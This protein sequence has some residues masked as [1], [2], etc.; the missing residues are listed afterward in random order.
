MMAAEQADCVSQNVIP[1]FRLT[2]E[3]LTDEAAA[4]LNRP[5]FLD[6][7]IGE[8]HRLGGAPDFMQAS[9]W[10]SC[11]SCGDAMT[12]YAQLDALPSGGFDLADAGLIH[13]FVC[14]DCFEVAASLD[15]A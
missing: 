9:E 8:R 13:V 2:P 11:P 14:F 4:L 10:P 15:T 7:S 6:P 3:P 5:R 1:P 12:F